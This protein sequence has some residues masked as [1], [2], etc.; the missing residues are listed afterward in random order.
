M[1]IKTVI[2]NLIYGHKADSERYVNYLRSIGVQIGEDVTIYTPTRTTIDECHP[3][4]ITIGSHV[5]ITQGVIILNHDYSWSVFK[6][7]DGSILGASGKVE[8]GDNV[9]IGMNAVITRNVKIGS[10]VVIGAGSVVTRDC[11][12]N[13]VYAGNPA[14]RIC[15]LE[16]FREKRAR[17]QL[18]EAR[19]LAVEY[20][21]RYGKMPPEDVFHEYFMLFE[22]AE[23]ARK[24]SWCAEKMKLCGN[25]EASWAYLEGHPPVFENFAAFLRYCFAAENPSEEQVTETGT[26]Q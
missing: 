24:K 19:T 8:I 16:E 15:S 3:W 23:S 22:T 2:R 9:F 10:N 20:F 13:G 26:G 17:A 11:P 4:M 18:E 12:D 5:R 7:Q 1:G 14:R 6:G 21:R 25:P